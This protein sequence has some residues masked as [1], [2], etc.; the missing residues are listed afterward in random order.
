MCACAPRA[1]KTNESPAKVVPDREESQLRIDMSSSEFV[2]LTARIGFVQGIV[3]FEF[4]FPF[5]EITDKSS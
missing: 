4:H 3:R 5:D 1:L 2:T